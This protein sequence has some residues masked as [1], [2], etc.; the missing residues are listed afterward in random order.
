MGDLSIVGALVAAMF[1]VPVVL[2]L[3]PR[4]RR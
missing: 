3:W 1:I 2:V 4:R